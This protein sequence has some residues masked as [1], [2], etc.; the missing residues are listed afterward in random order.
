[1][2]CRTDGAILH[3][4]PKAARLF[5]LEPDAAGELSIFKLLPPPVTLKV[6]RLFQYRNIRTETIPAVTITRPDSPALLMD[7]E[8]VLLE[9]GFVLLTFKDITRR[10]RLESHV[11]RLITAIDATPDVFLVADA[12]LKI[13]YVNPAFQTATGYGIEEVLG[14]SD[15]FLRVPSEKEAVGAYLEQV[16]QGREWLG[17]LVNVR[18]NGQTYRVESTVSPITDIAGQFMGYVVCERDLTMREQLQNALRAERD[19]VRSVLQSLDGAIY[20]LDRTFR[21]THANDGW[22]RLPSE[23]GGIRMTSAPEIGTKLLDHVPDPARQGELQ[24]IFQ[25]VLTTGKAQDNYFHAADGRHWVLKVSPW[26]NGAEVNGLICNIA[27][28]THYHDLQNQLFQSQ[29]M[30]IIGTLAAGVAHDFNNLLQVIMGHT[31]LILM[32]TAEGPSPLRQGLEKIDMAAVRATEITQQLLSFSRSSQEKNLVLDFNTVITEVSQL[33]RRTIRRN[34]NIELQTAPKPLPVKVNST[35]ASQAL[36]N[37]CVNAQDAMPEGGRLN[38]TNAAVKLSADLAARHPSV[39][40]NA[41]YAR[42]SVADTGSGIPPELL[43]RIFQPFFTTKEKGKGTGLGLSIVQRIVQEAGGFAEVDTTVGAGTTFHL[44][45]PLSEEKIATNAP[46]APAALSKGAG[47][48]LVVDDVDLVRDLA[49]ELLE[50]S[51][52]TVLTAGGGPEALK[53]LETAN[54]SVDVL[55]TDYNMPKMNGI[56]LIDQVAKR[57]PKTKFIMASGYLSETARTRSG[58]HNTQ[59]VLKPYDMF[60]VS[61]IIT[62]MLEG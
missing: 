6:E 28:Q 3:L 1:M 4:N 26:V 47:C 25:E 50:T 38:I 30:E 10:S 56:D 37:L 55:F 46:P 43:P 57:W 33:A 35:H 14:R 11:Q 8:I 41:T 12:D 36:L 60:E 59:L 23:H 22:Q 31:S 34:V 49:K 40:A 39:D 2:V 51:G 13:T 16:S 19:L 62:K 21:L 32:N 20:S 5:N 15:D 53:I 44:Y 7:L 54:P 9:S 29:K 52:L 61:K 24:T 48:V 17:E 58:E 18:K 45:L 42:C 27:D